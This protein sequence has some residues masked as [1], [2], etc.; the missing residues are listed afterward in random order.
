MTESQLDAAEDLQVEEA[1]AQRRRRMVVAAGA[2]GA[3]ALSVLAYL[4]LSGGGGDSGAF[5]IKPGIRR[6]AP[7]AGPSPTP[8]ALDSVLAKAAVTRV[9]P[10]ELP[11]RILA[12]LAPAVVAAAPAAPGSPNPVAG[13]GAPGSTVTPAT[14]GPAGSGAHPTSTPGPA[15]SPRVQYL[16]LLGAKRWG[17]SRW[18]VT[19]RT[20]R[21]VCTGVREGSRKVCGTDF[22]FEG[23]DGQTGRNTFVFVFGEV[24]GGNLIPDSRLPASPVKAG[25]STLVSVNGKVDGGISAGG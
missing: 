10:F 4:L 16:Q 15:V 20:Q 19:V 7:G 18:L 23:Q 9:D 22:T 14:S 13:G 25:N 17:G 24:Q 6:P 12:A 1:D 21:G 11:P 3:V 5:V 8:P 2:V